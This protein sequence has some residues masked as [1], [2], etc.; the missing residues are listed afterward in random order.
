M[1][2]IIQFVLITVLSLKLSAQKKIPHL[3]WKG[4]YQQRCHPD[5]RAHAFHTDDTIY[6]KFWTTNHKI[7]LPGDSLIA[8]IKFNKQNCFKKARN[9]GADL[10]SEIIHY[11]LD[12]EPPK[13]KADS[14]QFFFV[15]E[16]ETNKLIN[17]PG[18]TSIAFKEFKFDLSSGKFI[19]KKRQKS[20]SEVENVE[21]KIKFNER[22][23]QNITCKN[24]KI[25]Q[26]K[27]SLMIQKR[28]WKNGK[29]KEKRI[30]SNGIF[31]YKAE[32]YHPN[33]KKHYELDERDGDFKYLN[34]WDTNSVQMVTNGQGYFKSYFE[35]GVLKSEGLIKD[36]Q[37]DSLWTY[38]HFNGQIKEK[39][40]YSNEYYDIDKQG[41]WNHYYLNGK[42][43]KEKNL[44]K[45]EANYYHFNGKKVL[46]TSG[47]DFMNRQKNINDGISMDYKLVKAVKDTLIVILKMGYLIPKLKSKI[48]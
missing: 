32:G 9:K 3:S 2:R 14:F 41:K 13:S 29:I 22:I 27:D 33:G 43:K 23:I 30:Y 44:D 19:S 39:G 40:I 16:H 11:Y 12:F 18:F 38:Y 24:N 5:Y 26:E 20:K 4:E 42:I 47:T 36:F 6:F 46:E 31:D 15:L 37:M 25:P 10:E 1:Q 17:E 34:A 48:T 21:K 7:N 8:D 28:Y 35:N 45:N